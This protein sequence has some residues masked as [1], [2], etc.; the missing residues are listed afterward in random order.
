[1]SRS[2]FSSAGHRPST[3][4]SFSVSVLRFAVRPATTP[5]P[6]NTADAP[7]ATYPATGADRRS[8]RGGGGG[9]D[10]DGDAGEAAGGAL[11]AAGG[12]VRAT[13][14]ATS[15]SSRAC[16]RSATERDSVREPDE[17]ATTIVCGPGF[18]AI[19]APS[20][21]GDSTRPSS[22]TDTGA[23]AGVS[24]IESEGTR[25]A[26]AAASA[27]ACFAASGHGAGSPGFSG[28]RAASRRRCSASTS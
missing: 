15:S 10:E 4:D 17:P 18:T 24:T 16:S 5:S 2:A 19:G 12:G 27:A 8:A 1:M 3:Q 14:S 13:S 6:T 11:L 22:L 25:D 26:S 20:A 21:A 23:P 9:D 7:S 28:K